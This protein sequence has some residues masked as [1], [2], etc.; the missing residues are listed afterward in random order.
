MPVIRMP[1][2]TSWSL[3]SNNPLIDFGTRDYEEQGYVIVTNEQ[4]SAQTVTFTISGLSYTPQVARDFFTYE[5]EAEISSS[6]FAVTIPA[7]GSKVYV[8]EAEASQ[9]LKMLFGEPGGSTAA[10]SSFYANDGTLCN[11]A[12]L[13]DGVLTL[14]GVD[15]YVS[16]PNNASLNPANE[17][18]VEAWGMGGANALS[19]IDFIFN[20]YTGGGSS[21]GYNLECVS[22]IFAFTVSNSGVQSY[23]SSGIS[24]QEG[25]WYHVVGTFKNGEQAIYVNGQL[26]NSRTPSVSTI[27]AYQAA[28]T[29]SSSTPSCCFHGSMDSIRVYN[30][31]LSA[32]VVQNRYYNK[33]PKEMLNMQFSE[34]GGS[35]AED[36]S[37]CGNDGTLHNGAVLEDGELT[38]DG[39]DDYVS[40]PDDA[41]LN[42]QNELTV[43][44]WVMGGA[45]ALSGYDF[46]FSSYIGGDNSRGYNLQCVNG[47]FAFSVCNSG[48][49]SFLSSG[50]TIQEGVWYHVAGTFKNGEQVIYINGQQ[51]NQRTASVSSIGAY[52]AAK[53]ISSGTSSCSFHGSMDSVRVYKYALPAQSVLNHYYSSR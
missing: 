25:V 4:E 30:R 5:T 15:N 28:K 24:I 44:A 11:G 13:G 6:Q 17:L 19:G 37:F 50:V 9:V 36:S 52:Q 53:T 22:G 31:A 35:V 16:I 12:V 42:A 27:G 7:Y 41:S 45:N 3:S 49:Q 14:D 33:H 43:E 10:D 32:Q 39:V 8:L 20:S 38:L 18:T 48:V 34:L 46:I 40:I 29:I 47:V 1:H 51:A 2:W 23:L 21:R 26:A